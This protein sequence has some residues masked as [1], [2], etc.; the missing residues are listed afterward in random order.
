MKQI[1]QIK[2]NEV[3]DC[4]IVAANQFAI[5]KRVSRIR[6]RDYNGE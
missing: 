4:Q 5:Y 3:K 6:P 1:I 2:H